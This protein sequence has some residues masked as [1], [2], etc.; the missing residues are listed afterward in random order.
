MFRVHTT[1]IRSI[2]CWVAAYGFP[3]RVF[4]WV[5]VLRA[6]VCKVRMVPCARHHPHHKSD[7]R[8]ISTKP[9]VNTVRREWTRTVY[10][11]NWTS[12]RLRYEPEGTSG[13]V[14]PEDTVG[15]FV[16]QLLDMVG[17]NVAVEEY[18]RIFIKWMRETD[19]DNKQTSKQIHKRT[20]KRQLHQQQDQKSGSITCSPNLLLGAFAKLRKAYISF[21]V[22]VRPSVRMEQLGSHWTDF[23]RIWYLMIF[24]KS[25]QKTQVSL[26]FYKHNRNFTCRPTYIF[27]HISLSYSYNEKCFR[28]K[29]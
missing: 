11:Q 29:L 26:K 10:I 2:R 7:L 6:A 25:V 1:I 4:G 14:Q 23:H 15:L 5:V 8:F 24:R 19:C 3:H 21:A 13:I 9:T 28:Q 17:G 27:D 12:W 22:S 20:N 16:F 18:V